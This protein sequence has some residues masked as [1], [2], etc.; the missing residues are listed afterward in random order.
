MYRA[1]CQSMFFHTTRPYLPDDDEVLWVLAG[2]E[3]IEQ[4]M[5]HKEKVIQRFTPLIN[6]PKLLENNRVS[7]DWERVVEIRQKYSR[8]GRLSGQSRASNKRSTHDER[9]FNVRC[10][11]EVKRREEKVEIKRRKEK[12]SLLLS[13]SPTKSTLLAEQCEQI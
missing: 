7:Q 5:T 9:A 6:N 10:R 4:W 11:R 3:S 12:A 8:L 1:L 2:C 13:N